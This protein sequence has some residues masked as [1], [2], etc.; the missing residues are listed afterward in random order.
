[1]DPADIVW[2]CVCVA[3]FVLAGICIWRMEGDDQ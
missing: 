3:V 1:M 2:C